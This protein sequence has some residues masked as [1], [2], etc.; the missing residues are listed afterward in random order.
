M[1]KLVLLFIFLISAGTEPGLCIAEVKLPDG[2]KPG[3][4]RS[5]VRSLTGL[6]VQMRGDMWKYRDYVVIFESNTLK[7]IVKTSC[8]GKWADCRSFEMRSP[9]C[10]IVSDQ[11]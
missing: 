6:P 9:D 1:K 11:K 3:L 7:C 10:V 8:F 4:S 2:L 5:D